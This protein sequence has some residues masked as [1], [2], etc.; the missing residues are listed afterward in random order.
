[1]ASAKR[2]IATL[3]ITKKIA[4]TVRLVVY[5][6]FG[7]KNKMG[8]TTLLILGTSGNASVEMDADLFR[9]S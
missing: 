2:G 5:A 8:P 6:C 1:M 4:S 9:S 3:S 7:K